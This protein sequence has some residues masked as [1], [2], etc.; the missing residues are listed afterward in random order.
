LDAAEAPFQ[1]GRAPSPDNVLGV[2]LVVGQITAALVTLLVL[3]F[4]WLTERSRRQR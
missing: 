3:V 4:F 1:P 2:S